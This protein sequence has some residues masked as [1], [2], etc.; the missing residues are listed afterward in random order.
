MR[1]VVVGSKPTGIRALEAREE[2]M[3]AAAPKPVHKVSHHSNTI[4]SKAAKI[5]AEVVA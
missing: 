4:S 2:K 5:Q 1:D 3:A